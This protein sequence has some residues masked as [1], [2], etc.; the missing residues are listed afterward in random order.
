MAD[1]AIHSFRF[2]KTYAFPLLLFLCWSIGI[3]VGCG[4]YE[5]S[6]LPMMHRAVQLP[7]S[8]VGVFVCTFLP[9]ICTYFS[10]IANKPIIILIVCFLKSVAYGY[11]VKLISCVFLSSAW[12]V[13]LLFLFSDSFFLLFLFFLWI[14]LD[15]S[16][17]HK[18]LYRLNFCGILAVL[19]TLCDVFL[20][21]PFL[22]GLF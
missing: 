14:G 5:P 9:L 8:I 2:S 11:T 20:I 15:F 16:K 17:P 22:E 4:I 7:V 13:R 19:I 6:L 18:C 12:L 10:I 21:N 1:H 3:T